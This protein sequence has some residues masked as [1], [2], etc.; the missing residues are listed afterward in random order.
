MSTRS[1]RPPSAGSTAVIRSLMSG[2][3]ISVAAESTRICLIWAPVRVGSS[4][5]SS[6]TVAVTWG[7]AKEVPLF[8]TGSPLVS[9][10][11]NTS[12][13]MALR[14]TSPPVPT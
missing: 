7:V 12:W 10:P 4:A 2:L 6:A 13:A 1:T 9:K 3:A 14:V 8:T 11:V 5:C